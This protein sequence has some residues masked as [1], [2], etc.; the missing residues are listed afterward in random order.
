MAFIFQ[1]QP[2]ATLKAKQSTNDEYL[3]IKGINAS[4]SSA[5]QGAI[6]VNKFLALYGFEIAGDEYSSLT[7][8]KEG[9]DEE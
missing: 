7:I 6:E 4:L 5:T 3:T 8:V 1:P 2:V 9:V